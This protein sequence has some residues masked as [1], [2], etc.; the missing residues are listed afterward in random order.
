MKV[1]ELGLSET[2]QNKLGQ[3]AMAVE[4]HCKQRFSIRK[5]TLEIAALL[6]MADASGNTLVKQR[7][8]EF[9]QVL[10]AEIRLLL[11]RMTGDEA[12]NAVVHGT[13]V[14]YRGAQSVL[15]DR[16]REPAA[17]QTDLRKVRIYRGQPVFD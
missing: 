16:P 17:E 6:V 12:R 1:S 15:T 14:S 10:P 13:G 4:I 3:L 9:L 8:E 11:E 5:G 2:A 7:K